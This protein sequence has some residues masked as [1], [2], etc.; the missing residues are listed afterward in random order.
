MQC[1]AGRGLA[2]RVPKRIRTTML[3]NTTLMR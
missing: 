2:R 3:S 1:G